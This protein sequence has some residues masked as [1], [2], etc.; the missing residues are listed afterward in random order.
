MQQG[1]N[2]RETQ[3]R[4]SQ[5]FRSDDRRLQTIYFGEVNR[6]AFKTHYW[7]IDFDKDGA[8]DML[9]EVSVMNGKVAGFFIR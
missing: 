1:D 6:V 9:A 5:A 3:S 4:L 2:P 8:S 7:K